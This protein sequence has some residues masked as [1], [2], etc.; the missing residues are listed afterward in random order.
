METKK[1]IEVLVEKFYLGTISNEEVGFLLTYLKDREPKSALLEIYQNKWTQAKNINEHVDSDKLFNSIIRKLELKTRR[2]TVNMSHAWP[3][4]KY[5]AIFIFAFGLSWLFHLNRPDKVTFTSDQQQ[6]I[7]VPYGSKSRITLPDGSI[8]ALNSGS[9]LEYSTSEFN[10]ESRS[11]S[12]TGEGF[13]DVTKDAERPFYV[14]TPGIRLKVLGT[15]F[16]IKAYPDEKIEEATLVTGAVE[17]FLLSDEN[18]KGRPVILK[19]NQIAVFVKSEGT[20]HMD[21]INSSSSNNGAVK[22]KSVEL[23][24]TSRTEES[25]IWKDN[26]LVFDNEKFSSLVVKIERWYDVK[27]VV[28]DDELK[29]ARFTGKFDNETVEQVLN[30]LVNVTPFNYSIKQNLITITPKNKLNF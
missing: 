7:E 9:V 26:R 1:H 22:L 13:F 8:V 6:K 14:T 15:T 20:I 4:L 3:V 23:Q 12:I 10:L 16:N 29:N 2:V 17:I 30:A 21:S 28:N 24:T 27:I 11:V 19:P 5:A 18:E 25:I